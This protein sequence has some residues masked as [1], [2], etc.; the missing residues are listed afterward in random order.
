MPNIWVILIIVLS[1]FIKGVTG[2]GFPLL[3]FPLL[4][5]PTRFQRGL[6]GFLFRTNKEK[7]SVEN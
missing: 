3:S 5:L 1:S 2:F 6:I 4:R 7:D